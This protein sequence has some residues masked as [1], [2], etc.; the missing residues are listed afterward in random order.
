L[1]SQYMNCTMILESPTSVSLP[2]QP[3]AAGSVRP[4]FPQ[5]Q[6]ESDRAFEAFRVY[7]ELGPGRRYAAVGRKVGVSLRTIK[8]W[9]ADFDWP[10]RIKTYAKDAAEVFVETEQAVHREE[11]RD[12]QGFRDRQHVLAQRLQDAVERYLENLEG[13]DLDRM[14]LADAC[15]ALEVA[16][17]LGPQTE[18]GTGEDPAGTSR[19]LRDQLTSLLEQ[20]FRENPGK[21]VSDAPERATH[22]PAPPRSGSG[23]EGEVSSAD[24]PVA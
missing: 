18:R 6:G 22:L 11:L 14:S 16:S 10:G 8:R 13:G 23:N 5:A 17:R 19:S 24:S 21:D 9:A 15:K 7:L 2:P 3:P 4:L 1:C 12:A 20:V